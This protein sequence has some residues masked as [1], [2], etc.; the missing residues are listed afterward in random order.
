MVQKSHICL[1]K[2]INTRK[3]YFAHPKAGCAVLPLTKYLL[4]EAG[5][6]MPDTCR[7]NSGGPGQEQKIKYCI[8]NR[9]HSIQDES[10]LFCIYLCTTKSGRDESAPALS[11]RWWPS[12]INQG[13]FF[14]FHCPIL[15]PRTG[16]QGL[17]I[18]CI[19][20]LCF[21]VPCAVYFYNTV[22]P[23]Q[24]PADVCRQ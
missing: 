3:K 9:D 15:S 6:E 17:C 24:S 11:C 4:K 21:I 18:Q 22:S 19:P 13:F 23:R 5:K 20:I 12:R 7:K 8:G 14:T 1:L 16:I 2:N 10:L